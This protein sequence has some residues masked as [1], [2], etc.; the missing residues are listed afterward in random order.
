MSGTDAARD[1][2][3]PLRCDLCGAETASVQRVALDQDY[4]RLSTRHAVQYACQRCYDRKDRR[5]L[6]IERS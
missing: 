3:E 1:E 6:G 4:E 2:D 5:R